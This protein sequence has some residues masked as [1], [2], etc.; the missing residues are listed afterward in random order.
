MGGCIISKE[1][2]T[3]NLFYSVISPKQDTSLWILLTAPWILLYDA[4]P[5]LTLASSVATDT[6]VASQGHA[7]ESCKDRP[8]WQ[9]G[10]HTMCISVATE[11]KKKKKKLKNNT[12]ISWERTGLFTKCEKACCKCASKNGF[13]AHSRGETAYKFQ[14][15][16]AT[17]A[18]GCV[19]NGSKEW[20]GGDIFSDCY[21]N[22][23]CHP[24]H[25]ALTI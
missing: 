7:G 19:I 18:D 1:W 24:S 15:E 13:R 3:G 11:W 14:V 2:S 17:S 22:L 5:E 4:F 10:L 25:L 16:K 20:V 21:V 9:T 6:Y 12:S 8:V 23:W